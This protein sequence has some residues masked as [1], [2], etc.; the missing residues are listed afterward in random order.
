MHVPPFRQGSGLHSS[1]T[2]DSQFSP[3]YPVTHAHS[4]RNKGCV[5]VPPF[6]QG[7]ELQKSDANIAVVIATSP[8]RMNLSPAF[9]SVVCLYCAVVASSSAPTRTTKFEESPTMKY[10]RLTHRPS[11]RF[12]RQA[13]RSRS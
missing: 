12:Q 2:A 9:P 8:T 5:H 13:Y 3:S 10:R 1:L 11:S 7:E 6:T 4:Y